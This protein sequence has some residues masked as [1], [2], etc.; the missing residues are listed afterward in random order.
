MYELRKEKK[1][2]SKLGFGCLTLLVFL[3]ACGVSIYNVYQDIT[4]G[5]VNAIIE[6]V[7]ITLLAFVLSIVFWV[8]IYFV[9]RYSVQLGLRW[10]VIGA[11][12]G[13]IPVVHLVALGIILTISIKEYFY[14]KKKI[15]VNEYRLVDRICDT[16]YPI[17]MVHGVFFRDFRYLNYWGRIPDALEKN[18]AVLYYGEHQSAA[19]VAECGRELAQRIESIV[20]ETGWCF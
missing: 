9:Y 20:K 18:G 1:R 7:E 19:S 15:K 2:I 11:V 14:E 3:F 16:K 17:L 6:I 5:P 13:W 8:G 4:A 12:C 10:R